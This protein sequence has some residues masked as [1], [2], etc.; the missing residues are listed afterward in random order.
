MNGA[1]PPVRVL[2]IA[3]S[4]R[5]GS[6]ILDRILGQL[7][8]FFSVG[9]LANLWDRGLLA[10]RRCGC[11]VP[12]DQCPAWTAILARAFGQV[13]EADARRVIA[14][15]SRRVRVRSIPAVLRDRVRGRT[16]DGDELLAVLERLYRAVQ[17]HTGCRV[18]VDSSKAPL[19]GELLAAIPAIDLHVVHL[20]R[21]PRATAYSWLRRKQLPDF[22]DDRLMQRQRPLKSSGL[23]A[24]WQTMSELL[25]G[26]RPA[27]Y[28]RLR[29]EDF[30]RDPEAAVRC[31]VAMLGEDPTVGLPFEAPRTVRLRA[32]HS[33]SGNPNRFDNGAVELRPDREWAQRMRATDRALVTAVTWPLLLRYRYPLRRRRAAALNG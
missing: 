21:D 5:S 33:V 27:R 6:T 1:G 9:E 19:Y 3:G 16:V 12:V 10:H 25:I 2:Y 28:L 23:W 13:G 31:V 26:R 11:G 30:V 32:T 15:R 4:G 17:E 14:L 24:L 22:G 18:L 8:G 7:D 20:V 29:Y